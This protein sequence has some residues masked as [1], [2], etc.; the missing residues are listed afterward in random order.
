MQRFLFNSNEIVIA[1]N[2]YDFPYQNVLYELETVR[3]HDITY[4]N[5]PCAFDI[6]TTSVK[7]KEN[8]FMY[9]W[10]ACINETVVFGRTWKEYF[11]F[12]EYLKKY[13]EL[14]ENR[15]LVFYVH[16]LSYEFQFIKD[17]FKWEYIF[18]REKGKP[19]LARTNGIEYRCS[20]Y[21]SNMSLYKFCQNTKGVIHY[22]QD[23]FNYTKYR[24]ATT[25]MFGYELAYCYADVKGLCE[26]IAVLLKE[27]NLAT[28]PMTSTGYVRRDIRNKFKTNK[29]L[30]IEQKKLAL[31]YDLY[32]MFKESFRGGDTHANALHSNETID[33]V[34]S[35]D[36]SSSY[37]AWML[38][39]KFP[40]TP[41][42]KVDSRR[43]NQIIKK[44][45]A[46][47]F[48]VG[49]INLKHKKP[50]GDPYI[51]I[52]K[53]KNR[54]GLIEDNGRVLFA[55]T[56][57]TVITDIDWKII[58]NDYTWEEM[59]IG[60]LYIADYG[61]LPD[62]LKEGILEYAYSKTNLK[63]VKNYEYEYLKSKNKLNGI[64]G[65]IVTDIINDIITYQNGEWKND[66]IENID[67]AQ[68]LLDKFYKSRNSFL[69]YQ[70]GIW[71]TC[72]ARYHL[73]EMIW[74][75]D[76]DLVY[77]D[78]DSVKFIGE[79]NIEKIEKMN[80][81]LMKKINKMNDITIIKTENR[82]DILGLWDIEYDGKSMKFK[83][84]GAKKYI[85]QVEGRRPVITIAGVDKKAGSDEFYYKS[86]HNKISVFDLFHE[87]LVI[88]HAH[89]NRAVYNEKSDEFT[90]NV[91][92]ESSEYTLGI[93]NTYKNLLKN[94]KLGIDILDLI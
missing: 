74:E 31:D 37:P 76:D 56:L 73:R 60:R 35:A 43:F 36:L 71:V 19:L 77:N 27:D 7:E 42:H 70:W 91:Y 41:F 45:Y 23:R 67:Q 78:T 90:S 22:K 30:K 1:Y 4:Y 50:F 12:I 32:L 13:L 47:I 64:Y 17:F 65:M 28:I 80:K 40:M 87:G 3:K 52:A 92:I 68:E 2:I 21:L 16:N 24:D 18:A 26:C 54:K 61:Y 66:K 82:T 94:I 5:I 57:T 8:A 48:E 84:L 85:Y 93:T 51:A 44:G 39:E 79:E 63:G 81:Y 46:A 33:G 38:L 29:Y 6:E 34:Y 11:L 62:E 14:N 10:Q 89:H 83:T 59:R 49:F 72:W 53:S 69:S 20:Y 55:E 25:K 15:C 9:H 75:L 86:R 58:I 88:S